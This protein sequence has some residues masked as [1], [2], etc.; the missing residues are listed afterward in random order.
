[1]SIL[2][3]QKIRKKMAFLVGIDRFQIRMSSL[4]EFIAKDNPVRF[5]DVFSR[6]RRLG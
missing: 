2:N 1:M 6:T 3:Y 5:V 4:D